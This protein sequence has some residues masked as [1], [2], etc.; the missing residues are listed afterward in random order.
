LGFTSDMSAS[1][2][3]SRATSARR[4]S[5]SNLGKQTQPDM[6]PNQSPQ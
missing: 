5:F 1:C 6:R 2:L 3:V 4:D